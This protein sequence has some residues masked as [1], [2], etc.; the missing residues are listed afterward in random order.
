MIKRNNIII[1]VSLLA[2]ISAVLTLQ[3]F[4]KAICKVA[5]EFYHPFIS[6]VS[7]S[8]NA[9]SRESLGDKSREELIS[10]IVTLKKQNERE[11]A[12]LQLLNSVKNDKKGLED[13][14][15]IKPVPGY[16]C[17]FA[18]IY[19]RDPAF[20]YESFSINKGADS[21]IKP[22]SIVLCKTEKS[23]EN[24]HAFAVLGRVSRVEENLSQVNTIISQSCNLS[25]IIEGSKA[26]G[27]LKGGTIRN[28]EPYVKIAYLPIFKTYKNHADVVT[29]GLCREITSLDSTENLK[30][31]STPAGLFVGTVKGD[32]RIVNNLNAEADVSPGVD[33]D[34]IKYV[35]V[36]IEESETIKTDFIKNNQ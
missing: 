26:A 32:V 29:S 31:H 27:I 5:S 30:H 12:Q 3:I 21:G 7:H 20:W 14:L 8:E 28:A 34:S 6:P 19:I 9:F 1:L 11:R 15:K 4:K 18:E 24:K 23:D 16:K 33:F 36:L 2:I 13:L 35:I 25:V 17:V 10:E 22:G